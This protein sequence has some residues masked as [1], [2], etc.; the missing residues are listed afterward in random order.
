M[1][2]LRRLREAPVTST[3]IAANLGIY[4]WMMWVSGMK[5]GF[6]YATMTYFGANVVG[7]G[8][9][10]SHWRWVTAA[11]IHFNP[12]H[13][14]MNLWVLA[15]IGVV[16]ERTIGSGIVA[17]GYV[18]TGV[19]GN[20]LSSQINAWRQ[21]YDQAA[22]A[23]GAIMGL[24]GI[25]AAYAWRTKQKG[26]ARSL[27]MNVVFILVVGYFINLDNAA[28]LGG[29]VSGGVVGVLRARWP[30]PLPRWLDAVL[31]SAS[32][33]VSIAAFV[34]IRAYHGYH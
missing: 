24:I 23:S 20:V 33:A 11:F 18:L 30:R 5:S 17:A 22:G 34:I 31:V 29:F 28:H 19:L 21:H 12:L 2:W 3:L 16:S 6:D 26:I 9:D 15:Q 1:K 25:A 32:A 27:T 7:T 13:I 8:Q 14:I 10:A 4:V